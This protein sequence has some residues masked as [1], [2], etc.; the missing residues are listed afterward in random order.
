MNETTENVGQA[1][2]V[3]V[4]QNRKRLMWFGILPSYLELPVLL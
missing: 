1:I 4:T 3:I 2:S